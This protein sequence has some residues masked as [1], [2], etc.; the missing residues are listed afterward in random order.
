MLDYNIY[1]LHKSLS[2]CDSM[3]KVP[4]ALDFT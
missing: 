4:S 2:F 3:N 1:E